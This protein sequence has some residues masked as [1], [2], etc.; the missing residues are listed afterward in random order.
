[1]E[2]LE[3]KHVYVADTPILFIE[4]NVGETTPL[5][6]NWSDENADV[7]DQIVLLES[8]KKEQ[9]KEDPY[10]CFQACY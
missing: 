10:Y 3:N 5:C 7:E 1:M 2:N 4:N 6:A 9:L 8:R